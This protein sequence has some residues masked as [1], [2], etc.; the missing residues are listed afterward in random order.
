MD[1]KILKTKFNYQKSIQ[2]VTFLDTIIDE[3]INH[4]EFLI[5]ENK[6]PLKSISISK[7]KVKQ[8][9]INCEFKK[10]KL[11]YEDVFNDIMTYNSNDIESSNNKAEI[12]Y[13]NI[14]DEELNF[15]IPFDSS[16]N[17]SE[18]KDKTIIYDNT[19]E[20]II[21]LEIIIVLEKINHYPFDF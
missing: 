7:L 6:S 18:N 19:K 17:K 20:N 11:F 12:A 1:N 21:F 14:N 9:F 4:E 13:K 2:I 3:V 10:K 8:D 5:N 15:S 16:L